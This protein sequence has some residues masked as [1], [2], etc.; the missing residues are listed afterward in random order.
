MKC[1]K[2]SCDM[3]GFLFHVEQ[4]F[5]LGTESL[6]LPIDLQSFI[7]HMWQNVKLSVR[8][9]S[10]LLM[11]TKNHWMRSAQKTHYS[12]DNKIIIIRAKILTSFLRESVRD[13]MWLVTS[14]LWRS[15][16]PHRCLSCSRCSVSIKTSLRKSVGKLSLRVCFGVCPLQNLAETQPAAVPENITFIFFF[17]SFF[18]L[19]K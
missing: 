12:L 5:G 3:F 2:H 16:S 15:S 14:L 17:F 10:I 13:N 4:V 1:L 11:R 9:K 19:V 6:L 18:N 7:M 8:P